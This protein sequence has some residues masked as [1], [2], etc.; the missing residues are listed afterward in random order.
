MKFQG[1]QW[2]VGIKNLKILYFASM[3]GWTKY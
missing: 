2:V 3:V 1:W